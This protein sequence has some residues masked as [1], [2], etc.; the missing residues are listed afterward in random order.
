[1][2]GAV[3]AQA[4]LALTVLAILASLA[5]A[6]LAAVEVWGSI[7]PVSPPVF[8]QMPYDLPFPR[9]EPESVGSGARAAGCK[10]LSQNG[11]CRVFGAETRF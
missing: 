9:K 3:S 1:M 7:H 6:A 4:P 10:V 11:L 2:G 8:S 5:G